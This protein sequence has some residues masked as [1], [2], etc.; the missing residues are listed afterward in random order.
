MAKFQDRIYE[1][2]D[3]LTSGFRRLADFLLNNTLDAAFL[4]VAGVS[5]RTGVDP[6]TV[7]RFAQEFGYSGYREL[8][9]EIKEYVR[10]KIKATYTVPEEGSD[11]AIVASVFRAA[12]FNIDQFAA[13][14]MERIVRALQLLIEAERLWVTGEHTS[15]SLACFLSDAF[16]G[17]GLPS[18]AFRPTMEEAADVLAR[19]GKGDVLIG[20]ALGTPS[21]DVGY[22]VRE[23]KALG[24]KTIVLSESGSIFPVRE[25]D[26]PLVVPSRSPTTLGSFAPS[27][28]VMMLLWES[29]LAKKPQQVA[30]RLTK[31]YEYLGQLVALRMETASFEL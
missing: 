26:I 3:E 29:Y 16:D 13:T 9:L 11:E 31:L 23:A 18:A 4:T 2:Y 1:R 14:E 22:V 27:L 7:V 6:A 24:V 25:A 30:D 12:S 19:M 17:A 5:R 28:A 8:S 20:I 21:L 15:Y 10:Q